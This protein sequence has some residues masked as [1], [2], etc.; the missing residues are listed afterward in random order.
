VVAEQLGPPLLGR[1]EQ[2]APVHAARQPA[3]VRARIAGRVGL[4]SK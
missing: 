4:R 2:D 3:A 1:V